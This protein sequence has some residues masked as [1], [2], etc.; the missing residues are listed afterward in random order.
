MHLLNEVTVQ[1][2]IL[3]STFLVEAANRYYVTVHFPLTGIFLVWLFLRHR[4]SYYGV[5]NTLVLLTLFGLMFTVF[6]PLAPPRLF[7]GRPADRHDADLRAKRV[8]PGQ[9][10]RRG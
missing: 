2:L 3:H 6:V 1:H 7:T 9:H 4:G 5:R 8:Q 10:H